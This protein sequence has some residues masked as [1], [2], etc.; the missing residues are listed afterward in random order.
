[1][2]EGRPSDV[3]TS[4][5]NE[6]A[7]LDTSRVSEAAARGLGARAPGR[8]SAW[9]SSVIVWSRTLKTNAGRLVARNRRASRRR[10]GKLVVDEE[11]AGGTK[12]SAGEPC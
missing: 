2:E 6:A 3:E 7:Q 11:V 12:S 4:A 5:M 8:A 1:M 9:T 10:R